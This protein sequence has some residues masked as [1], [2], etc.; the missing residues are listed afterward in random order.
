[1]LALLH[2]VLRVRNHVHYAHLDPF[3]KIISVPQLQSCL[4]RKRSQKRT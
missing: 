3:Y 1:L 4:A 2:R